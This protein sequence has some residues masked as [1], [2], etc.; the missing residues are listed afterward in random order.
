MPVSG[1]SEANN[2]N[3]IHQSVNLLTRDRVLEIAMHLSHEVEGNIVEFGVFEGAS[4][5]VLRH[6]L[7]RLEQV[8]ARKVQ[9]QIF[10][11]DSFEGLSEKFENLEVGT[12]A[13]QP[14]NIQGVEVVE[15]YFEESLTP[16]LARRVGKVAFASLDADLYS[17]TT[18]ALRWLT[19]LLHT[20]SLLLFDEFLA[21]QESEKRAFHDWLAESGIRTIKIAE[22]VRD[23]SAGGSSL[24]VRPLFQVIGTAD[25]LTVGN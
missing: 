8:R 14:P 2:W 11:C 23:P 13:C 17:S 7:N 22:F 10:A 9:K 19:P 25:R 6:V 18:C 4:T 12:F 3:A 16:E 21:G 24:D 5:R 1:R 20:G 15:G